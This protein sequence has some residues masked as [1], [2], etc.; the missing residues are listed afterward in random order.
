VHPYANAE[1][2]QRTKWAQT[3]LQDTWDLV[4]DP[5]DTRRDQSDFEEPPLVLTTTE[6]LPPRHIFL[7][8]S[9]DPQYYGEAVGN[10]FWE[11]TM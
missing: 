3:T 4:D 1:P 5:V 7:F 9:S 10:P 2:E 8:Q 11:S 6:P